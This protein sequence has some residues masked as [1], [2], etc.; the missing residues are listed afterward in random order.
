MHG[1]PGAAAPHARHVRLATGCG[2][3][4][5]APVTGI[6]V[7]AGQT[8]LEVSLAVEQQRIEQ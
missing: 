3:R 8:A 4:D 2:C 7:G 6:S 1:F 5:A